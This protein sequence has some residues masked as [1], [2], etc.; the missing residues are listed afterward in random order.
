[1]GETRKYHCESE[2]PV[3]KDYTRYEFTD[4]W[5]LDPKA[6]DTQETLDNLMKLKKKEGQN[7]DASVLLRRDKKHSWGKI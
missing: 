7:V 3:T 4:K 1:M 6:Q 2:C 5:I